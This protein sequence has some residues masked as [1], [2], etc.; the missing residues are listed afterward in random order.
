[1]GVGFINPA[2]ASAYGGKD[3][4][5]YANTRSQTSSADESPMAEKWNRIQG[6]QQDPPE[7]SEGIPQPP[8]VG[9]G[10]VIP[11]RPT[12]RSRE[13]LPTLDLYT[14]G[15]DESTTEGPS[16]AERIAGAE[17]MV[18]DWEFAEDDSLVVLLE[19]RGQCYAIAYYPPT[20]S[21]DVP[22]IAQHLLV[23][24]ANVAENAPPDLNIAG[25]ID[26]IILSG[27]AEVLSACDL[28]EIFGVDPSL[29]E[30]QIPQRDGPEEE[31]PPAGDVLKKIL[32][33]AA[34]A[35]ALYVINE[36][37]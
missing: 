19:R 22:T 23:I 27:N 20:V 17:T 33:W 5:V 18:L 14:Q 24:G 1:M 31:A 26:Q 30:E 9:T 21:L 12:A 36:Q 8:S 15:G 32:P 11:L 2:A 4:D 35:G 37:F 34:L 6:E 7:R 3:T 16:I 25:S 28:G 13:D 29:P 10:N